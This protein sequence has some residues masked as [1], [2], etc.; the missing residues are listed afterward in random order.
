MVYLSKVLQCWKKNGWGKCFKFLFKSV[1]Q[2]H[3]TTKTQQL[4][5]VSTVSF[6]YVHKTFYKAD[7]LIHI[8]IV[9]IGVC[10]MKAD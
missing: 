3:N 4:K 9:F 10:L 8:Q 1:Q 6:L 7:H 5:I 2:K